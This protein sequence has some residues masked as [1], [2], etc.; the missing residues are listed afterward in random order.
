MKKLILLILCLTTFNAFSQITKLKIATI[1]NDSIVFNTEKYDTWSQ[2]GYSITY[3]STELVHQG[4]ILNPDDLDSYKYYNGNAKI[5]SV[6]QSISNG[7]LILDLPSGKVSIAFNINDKLSELLSVE[8]AI[9][10]VDVNIYP[11]PVTDI[12]NVSVN[13]EIPVNV[14]ITDING[15]TVYN[16]TTAITQKIDMSN[17]SSGLYTV[18][19]GGKMWKIMKE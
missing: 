8:D 15:K 5:T 18:N 9:K 6:G 2:G 10:D 4:F 1:F 11:N 13:S 7:Y 19:V 12:L 16:S 3:Y 14:S 17:F